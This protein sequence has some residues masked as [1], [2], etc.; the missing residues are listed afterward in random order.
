MQ[1]K[2]IKQDQCCLI[3]SCSIQAARVNRYLRKMLRQSFAPTK[4]GFINLAKRSFSLILSSS[5]PTPFTQTQRDTHAHTVIIYRKQCSKSCSANESVPN[6]NLDW[7]MGW[8]IERD[9]KWA[10]KLHDE[11]VDGAW[12]CNEQLEKSFNIWLGRNLK[13]I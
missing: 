3:L 11:L 12:K 2:K 1:K 9:I 7:K 4:F 6:E 13:I 5:P 8:K 10:N